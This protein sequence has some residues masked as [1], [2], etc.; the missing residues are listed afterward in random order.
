MEEL[1]VEG[2]IGWVTFSYQS[3]NASSVRFD[4]STIFDDT[5]RT[6]APDAMFEC[7]IGNIID[8]VR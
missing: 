4:G 2:G 8:V 1:H 3:S 6:P 5:Q 7:V